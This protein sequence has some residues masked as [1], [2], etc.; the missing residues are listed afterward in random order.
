MLSFVQSCLPTFN[1]LSIFERPLDPITQFSTP[2]FLISTP[3]ALPNLHETLISPIHISFYGIF[4]CF[5]VSFKHQ[6]KLATTL[7]RSAKELK[8]FPNSALETKANSSLINIEFLDKFPK[9]LRYPI[10]GFKV[11][12]ACSECPRATCHMNHSKSLHNLHMCVV[13][14]QSNRSSKAHYIPIPLYY[15]PFSIW[16]SS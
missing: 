5:L 4:S 3:Q 16:T 11:T 15:F 13:E 10:W 6:L 14:P 2:S 1:V 9:R 12:N 7:T 8:K